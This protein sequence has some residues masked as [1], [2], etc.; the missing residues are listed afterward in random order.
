MTT[1]DTGAAA[2]RSVLGR[3]SIYTLGTAAPI[4]ANAA[5]T[6]AVTR[7][8][9]SHEYGL[10]ATAIVVIQIGMMVGSLGMPSVITRHG[11]LGGS[12][13]AGARALLLRGSALTAALAVLGEATTPLWRPLAS[14]DLRT[15][16]AIAIGASAFFVV[17]ENA[18][19]MLR[20]LD[21]PG[22]FV[23]LSLLATLGG[24][25]TGLLL[26][27]LNPTAE[28]YVLG[29]LIGYAVSAATGIA[30]SLRGGRPGHE[31]GDTRAALKLGLPM[32]PHMV[33][34]YLANGAMVFLAGAMYGFSAAARLQVALL[35]GVSP[36]VITSALN[37][38][39]APTIFRTD[40]A[41]RPVVLARTTGDIA[42]LAAL[43]A[44]GVS[45]LSPWLLRLAAGPGFGPDELVPSVGIAAFGTVIA[46][47]Y[48]ANVHLVFAA[49]RSVGLSVVTPAS[50][51]VGLAVAAVLG[52]A[53]P[54]LIAAGFPA[55]YAALALGSMWLRRRVG[56]PHWDQRVLLR[57]LL[58]GALF[59][60][61]GALLPVT[62]GWLWLR[63]PIAAGLGA[64]TLLLG[65]KVLRG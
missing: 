53:D 2:S 54:I 11:L 58:G 31:P 1:E 36:G 59:C 15:V 47:G 6:P 49:G 26:I 30:L 19:A 21:R 27:I 14:P 28:G 23:S 57:P 24:P 46:V 16:L 63:L 38:S 64:L 4:L 40:P 25:C 22:A 17:V 44:G 13:V 3:G 18:Q 34:L 12:G 55:T 41:D 37:N 50:L 43:V 60:A 45:V 48:L 35:I 51:V 20:V 32:L 65:R 56:G 7:I 10:V 9:G 29:L 8:L 62:G 5:V 61:L 39:W 42:T 52:S 33:A